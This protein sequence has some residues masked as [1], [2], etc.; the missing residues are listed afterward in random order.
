[1]PR[2]SREPT[3][4]RQW[5]LLK[6]IPGQR[7]GLTPRDLRERLAAAGHDVTKRTVERDLRE[8]SV[9][10]PLE[11]N[12][13]SIPFGWHW[14]ADAS[15]DI[16]GIAL[17]EAVSLGLLED[18]LGQLVPPA[19]TSAL[20]GRFN[21]AADKLRGLSQNRY[22]KWSDLVRYVQPGMPFL[23][24]AIHPGVLE[25][26]QEALLGRQQIRAVYHSVG[27]SEAR[28]R[29]LHPLA[30]I[31]QGARSYLLATSSDHHGPIQY[32]LHRFQDATL[33][34][35]PTVIPAGFSLDGFL[36]AGGAQ[37]GQG[38]TITL[39]ATVSDDLANILRETPVSPSQSLE[40]RDGVHTL[41]ATVRDS[42]QL[43]FWLLSQGPAIV[44]LKPAALRKR[45]VSALTKT[46]AAYT[47]D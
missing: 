4:A 31:Q 16:P 12:D 8:L 25:T 26:I 7:P 36:A 14:R 11:C 5:E 24:P 47:D 9:V 10:F 32:A 44:V 38:A 43:G 28:E 17:A 40:T 23:P 1:M 19:F 21:A 2:N 37:F 22:A 35:K 20:H 27:A 6:L 33:L 41:T 46:L 45:L 34:E 29:V 13:T 30:L 39:K 3:L 42:W 15:F 18:L